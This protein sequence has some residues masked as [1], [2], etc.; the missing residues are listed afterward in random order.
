MVK[1]RKYLDGDLN[2]LQITEEGLQD[3]KTVVWDEL[4]DKLSRDITRTIIDDN[5]IK[6]IFSAI[7][8]NDG[9][10]FCYYIRDKRMSTVF[11]RKIKTIV[12]KAVKTGR[13]LF[14]LSYGGQDR[15]HEFLGFKKVKKIGG[16]EL[17]VAS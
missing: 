7:R 15:M 17:W 12:K 11:E 5:G 16:R 3:L 14:T 2:D 8:C 10:L 13:V 4:K 6:S 9:S 1:I